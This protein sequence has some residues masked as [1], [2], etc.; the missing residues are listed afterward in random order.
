MTILITPREVVEITFRSPSTTDP[1]I[2]PE[3]AIIAA[4]EKFL[5]PA[6]G[7]LY[8]A[9]CEGKYPL[10][11]D[12]YL[13]APLALYAKYLSLQDIAVQGG[14]S[15]LSEHYSLNRRPASDSARQWSGR[16]LRSDARSLLL[17]AVKYIE[18]NVALY[19]E[20]SARESSVRHSSIAGGIV[21][22]R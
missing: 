21:I 6:L 2:I 16:R 13:K 15:G 5:R 20:Y 10:L 14:T 1:R 7:P 11:T 8:E 4:Q 22:T 17:A 12:Q 9:L 18:A 3:S 19:P